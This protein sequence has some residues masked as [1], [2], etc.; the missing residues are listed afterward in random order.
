MVADKVLAEKP[1][2]KRQVVIFWC[3]CDMIFKLNFNQ[4]SGRV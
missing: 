4:W 2:V 1:E 3:R